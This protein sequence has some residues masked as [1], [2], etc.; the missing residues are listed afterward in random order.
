[1]SEHDRE[2]NESFHRARGAI[3]AVAV[4]MIGICGTMIF[5][6]PD[7]GGISEHKKFWLTV[8]FSID[9]LA[10]LIMQYIYTLALSNWARAV[11]FVDLG[12]EELKSRTVDLGA[13]KVQEHKKNAAESYDK[14]ARYFRRQQTAFGIF[15]VI[16]HVAFF[17]FLFGLMFFASQWIAAL[18]PK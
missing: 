5:K 6:L 12:E 10:A 4:T 7:M 13:D 11:F 15:D 14:A 9:A 8:I 3:T 1:M 17:T 2:I 18:Q 16:Y